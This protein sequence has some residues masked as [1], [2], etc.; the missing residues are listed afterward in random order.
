MLSGPVGSTSDNSNPTCLP[1]SHLLH[2]THSP[3]S[4]ISLD[5]LIK[6]FWNLESLGIKQDEP[7]V[8]EEFQK[9]IEFKNGRYEVSLP[10]K[11]LQKKLPSNFTLAKKRLLGLLNRLRHNPD[12]R[13]EYQAVIQN[14]LQQGIVEE[15]IEG[16]LTNTDARA[17]YL[18]HHAVI[19]K[20]KQTTK[21][22]IVYDASARSEGISLNDSL[23]SGPK[24]NQNILDIIV[25]FRTY[26]IALVADM[27]KAFLMVSVCSRDR[28]ALR[29]LWVDDVEKPSPVVKKL[30]FTRVV[31]GVSASP[32]L[33]NATINHHLQKYREEHPALVHTLMKS[34]YVDDVTFGADGENEAYNL[35][36]LSK[37]IFAASGFNLR[38]FV[39]NSPIVR[40]RIALDEQKL[41]NNSCT[42]SS[43][44]EEDS[45]YTSNLLAGSTAGSL[46]VLGVGWNPV[47]DVLEF[48]LR[49]I[50]NSLHS[51]KPTKCN[52]VG[53]AS[54]FYDPL[55]FLSPVIVT[56]KIFFQEMC[57]LKLD[58]DDQL[59]NEL[60]SKW[61]D[62]VSRF[63]GTVITLP[64][65]YIPS[66]GT[67]PAYVSPNNIIFL[68]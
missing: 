43:V 57:K 20:D 38:K 66:L 42:N 27:E 10:W 64:R 8:Y 35:Y 14:Q 36:V 24:F 5:D 50:A 12:I 39:T 52:I 2:I 28:D 41:P 51:L 1:S 46:K 44:M 30:R 25:R 63:Q 54:R 15:V 19:R 26:R 6:A 55:G 4:S 48:D 40:Q 58:W 65:C 32:F 31:L 11:P 45:T 16:T 29:F 33:L 23:F 59:P 22:C 61:T 37:K 53:F 9:K 68:P 47:N 21:L 17:H 62:I 56:L 60:L 13:R 7:S 49:E 67:T 34:I 18:S 3:D